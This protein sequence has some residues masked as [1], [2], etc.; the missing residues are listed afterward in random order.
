M[1]PITPNKNAYRFDKK[2][3]KLVLLW[4]KVIQTKKDAI[5]FGRISMLLIRSLWAKERLMPLWEYTYNYKCVD[6]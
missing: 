5:V 4:F 3:E 6:A 1:L 2:R